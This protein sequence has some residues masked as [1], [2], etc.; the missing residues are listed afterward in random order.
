MVHV[1]YLIVKKKNRKYV[2]C[3]SHVPQNWKFFFA[4][5]TP[6]YGVVD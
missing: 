4:N 6:I 2:S 5:L 1:F 3:E